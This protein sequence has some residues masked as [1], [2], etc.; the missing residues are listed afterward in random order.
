MARIVMELTNR[1]NLH[2]GHCLPDRHGGH[3]DL[4]LSIIEEILERARK[5]GFE[6]IVFTGGEPTLHKRFLDVV[7]KTVEAGYLFGFV[8]NGWNFPKLF[9]KLMPYREALSGITFSMDGAREATHDGLRGKGSYR[10]LLKA[11]SVCVLKRIPFSINMVVTRDNSSE[12]EEQVELA[13]RLGSRGVRFGHLMPTPDSDQLEL[14]VPEKQAVE[15]RIQSLQKIASIPVAIAPGYHTAELFPCAP[16]QQQEINVD[17]QGNVTLCC[18]L[19][20][21]KTGQGDIAGNL[22]E[23]SFNDAIERL[24]VIHGHYCQEKEQRH[25][26]GALQ[27]QDYFPCLYCCQYFNKLDDP[28]E[29]PLVFVSQP[30]AS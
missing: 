9:Q 13:T 16:L 28:K 18:H 22:Q 23:I 2:C 20:G 4:P 21:Y 5:S 12:L 8:S 24:D 1:C 30:S 27:N 3:G 29:A 10:R 26:A 25:A 11:M 14:S 15:M 19:S 6:E 17:W 7:A